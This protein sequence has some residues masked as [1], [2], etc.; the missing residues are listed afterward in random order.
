MRRVAAIAML[1][2]TAAALMAASCAATYRPGEH[3]AREHAMESMK[4]RPPEVEPV[5]GDGVRYEVPP[6]P[7]AVGVAQ[8]S[9]VIAAVNESTG[10]TL[11]GLAIYPI[12]VD[13]AEEEDASDVF[14][15]ALALTEGGKALRVE[16]EQGGTYR[17]DLATRAVTAIT[18]R[19]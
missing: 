4:R 12:V 5:T 15:T 7:R 9:G 17:V 18:P 11:W 10:E 13:E 16:D 6:A 1:P 2:V 8:S 19:R 14:I 3:S